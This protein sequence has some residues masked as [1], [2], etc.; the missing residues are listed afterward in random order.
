MNCILKH[1]CFVSI[2]FLFSFSVLLKFLKEI[3]KFIFYLAGEGNE[4][5]SNMIHSYIKEI[6]DL[7]CSS[8]SY[9]VMHMFWALQGSSIAVC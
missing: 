3:L 6:E 5:I 2:T 1:Y 8:C 7:R 4:E 9:Y